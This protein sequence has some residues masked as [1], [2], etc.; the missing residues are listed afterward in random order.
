[1]LNKKWFH[2]NGAF[3]SRMNEFRESRAGKL[4]IVNSEGP[5]SRDPVSRSAVKH[6]ASHLCI[7]QKFIR[8]RVVKGS[9]KQR[10]ENILVIGKEV[11]EIA[12]AKARR[13]F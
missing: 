6:F 7:K 3:I 11:I 2:F 8:R 13:G 12:K 5:L 1:M 9:P 10:F 4:N